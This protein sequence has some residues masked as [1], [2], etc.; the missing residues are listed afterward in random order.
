[1]Q[2]RKSVLRCC[3]ALLL[4]HLCE[5]LDTRQLHEWRLPHTYVQTAGC[6]PSDRISAF[7]EYPQF[8]M[9]QPRPEKGW[10]AWDTMWLCNMLGRSVEASG[11]DF[12]RMATGQT[13][14]TFP[15]VYAETNNKINFCGHV[16]KAFPL[17]QGKDFHMP[18][19]VLPEDSSLLR[20]NLRE[21]KGFLE[22][23]WVTKPEAG[24][25]GKGLKLFSSAQILQILEQAQRTSGRVYVQEYLH[26]TLLLEYATEQLPETGVSTVPL[27]KV[28]F[29]FRVYFTIT[30]LQPLRVWVH[31]YGFSRLS[32]KEF[33]LVGEHARD[34]QRHV[35]NVDFQK[36]QKN[37]R[38][39]RS[40]KDDCSGATRSLDCVIKDIANQTGKS[41]TDVWFSICDVLGKTGLTVQQALKQPTSCTGC[42]QFWGADLV[43][44]SKGNPFML[45]INSSPAIDQEYLI[46]MG[47][48]LVSIYPELWKLKG[49][50]PLTDRIQCN[51]T[52]LAKYIDPH[53]THRNGL[54]RRWLLMD[55]EPS[56]TDTVV[57]S[58]ML[59][60]MRNRGGFDLGWP[61]RTAVISRLDNERVVGACNASGVS[62]TLQ[63]NGESRLEQKDG[64]HLLSWY[65]ASLYEIFFLLTEHPNKNILQT[66]CR[67]VSQ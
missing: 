28:K 48:G 9:R 4:T 24:S 29:D 16:H 20:A 3:V 37:Y 15:G 59:S 5:P 40:S 38:A 42:Y 54:L 12:E 27:V 13:V 18:C 33:S 17:T 35:A 52:T 47:T 34:L 60:E 64:S 32:T 58:D 31:R 23:R 51:L 22:R 43:F 7:F 61:T 14:N 57:I 53:K 10:D 26:K 50:D 1:M 56:H 8:R 19:F 30:S 11:V 45:E 25:G 63:N 41:A 46:M 36:K 67:P 2:Q 65:D 39:P 55:V 62:P 6:V 21:G 49:V 44:D 66:N